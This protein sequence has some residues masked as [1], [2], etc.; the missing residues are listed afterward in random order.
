M[1]RRHLL[2][3]A[4]T[5]LAG[6]TVAGCLTDDSTATDTTT[7]HGDPTTGA[8]TSGTTEDYVGT[9]EAS[10]T[11]APDHQITA[12]NDHDEP[13]ELRVVV[14]RTERGERVETVHESAR[15]LAPGSVDSVYN[16]E[17]ANPDG[18]QSFAVE[19]SVGGQLAV[20]V[21]ETSACYGDL[22]IVVDETGE[23]DPIY[24]IC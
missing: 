12:R 9:E 13:H 14:A 5:L 24:A 11:P 6:T 15:E 1:Q 4:T 20:V 2:A 7:T 10:N 22:E 18:V 17:D 23:L 16:L 21:L 19:S 8:P 3:T